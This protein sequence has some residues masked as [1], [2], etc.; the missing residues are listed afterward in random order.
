MKKRA[1]NPL[2]WMDDSTQQEEHIEKK[3]EPI[4][5][6]NTEVEKVIENI[7]A[8]QIDIAPNYNDWISIGFAF[9]DEFGE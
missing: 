8:N 3:S 6:N 9:A 1:F 5:T 2:E 4:T 7:E